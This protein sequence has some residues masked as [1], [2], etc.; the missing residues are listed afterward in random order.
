[1]LEI[2]TAISNHAPEEMLIDMAEKALDEYKEERKKAKGENR[3]VSQE[4]GRKVCFMFDL[5][6]TRLTANEIGKD[7]LKEKIDDITGMVSF[8]EKLT[9]KKMF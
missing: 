2:F 6:S 9:G 1:M 3:P 4:S 5:L 8:M 7:K